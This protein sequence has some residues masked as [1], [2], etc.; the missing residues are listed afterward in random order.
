MG[1]LFNIFYYVCGVVALIALLEAVILSFIGDMDMARTCWIV[2]GV[3]GVITVIG[4]IIK[5]R[6]D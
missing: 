3:F 5:N 4:A 6:M 2:F 1:C